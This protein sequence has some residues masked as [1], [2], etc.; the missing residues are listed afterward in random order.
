M[1]LVQ[2]GA[3]NAKLA[4][5]MIFMPSAVTMAQVVLD[6]GSFADS[7]VQVAGSV[8]PGGRNVRTFANVDWRGTRDQ[9]YGRPPARVVDRDRDRDSDDD[10]G[11]FTRQEARA[12]REVWPTIR[13]AANFHDINWHSVGLARAPGDREA[14]RF[15]ADDWES[16][17][18]AA[19]FDDINWRAEYR[20]F[21]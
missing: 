18:R 15:M 21:R 9:E 6:S 4:T 7:E 3:V 5:F 10:T 16:L 2:G 1:P 11:P 8:T 17:R 13:E 14:R 12:L 19:Q 20:R